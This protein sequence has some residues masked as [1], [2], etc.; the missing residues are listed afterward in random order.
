MAVAKAAAS[1][2]G[3]VPAGVSELVAAGSVV[4]VV[5][6]AAFAF[7]F[8]AASAAAAAAVWAANSLRALSS[9]MRRSRQL[10]LSLRA[11]TSPPHPAM[12]TKATITKIIAPVVRLMPN[13]PVDG[14][15]VGGMEQVFTISPPGQY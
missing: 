2:D 11:M 5:V 3:L 10:L 6:V 4:A 1:L 9:S 7:G 12:V 8:A 13:R 14:V 15:L